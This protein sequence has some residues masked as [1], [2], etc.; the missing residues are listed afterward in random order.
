[1]GV[2]GLWEVLAK[3]CHSRSLKHLAVVD[4]F[5]DNKS[6]RRGFR[7]GIDASIWYHHA[8]CSKGGKNPQ[9]RLLFYRLRSLAELPLIPLFVFDGRERPKVKRGSRMGKSGSHN[10]TAGMKKLLDVFGMEWRMALGEAEAELASLNRT[11]VIDAIMT[12][13]VDAFVFGARTI[14][15]NPSLTLTGNKCNPALNSEGKASKYHVMVYTAEQILVH[16]DVAMSRGGLILFALLSGG[17]YSPGLKGFGPQIAHGL[18][19]CG[20]GDR[21]LA[22]YEDQSGIGFHQSL[23]SWRA[24]INLELHTN[25]RGFL[26]RR[27]PSLSLPENFPD[28][29][30]LENYANPM[31]SAR[32]GRQGGGALRDSGNPHLSKIAGF[33]EN[34]FDEWGYKSVIIKRFRDLMWEAA[35]MTILRRAALDADEKEKNKRLSAG[36]ADLSVRGPLRPSRVDEIGTPAVLVKKILDASEIDRYAAAFV[37]REPRN[38]PATGSDARPL[39]QRIAGARQHVSTDGLLEYRVEIDPAQLVDLASAGIKGKHPEPPTSQ[40]SRG[41][42]KKAAPDPHSVLRLW[43]PASIMRQVHPG[44][45][46]DFEAAEAAKATKR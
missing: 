30:V 8:Q 38:S 26:L 36:G 14:I 1:M 11:G 4:G 42:S 21:L 25:A 19:R 9:L 46:E 23:R 44:L 31:C 24:E 22:A 10:L 17:D 27:Y 7:V 2:Q 15:R 34:H 18:A 40:S 35:I 20:F 43:I 6:G 41:N 28:Q 3:A 39:M 37:R 29:Q 32:V 16:P 33:C 5:E 45:V 12:D 13:D